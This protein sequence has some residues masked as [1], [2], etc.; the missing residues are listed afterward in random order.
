MGCG[1]IEDTVRDAGR[2]FDKYVRNETLVGKGKDIHD[3][4]VGGVKSGWDDLRGATYRKE[5]ERAAEAAEAARI[6]AK[7][8]QRG[9]KVSPRKTEKAGSGRGARGTRLVRQPLGTHTPST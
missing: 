5:L 4:I 2:S 7:T 8:Y 1:G 6:Q 3:D 9:A